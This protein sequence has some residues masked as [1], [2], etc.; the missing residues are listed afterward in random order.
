MPQELMHTSVR[1]IYNFVKI[2]L[3]QCLKVRTVFNFKN[4]RALRILKDSSQPP[5][6]QEL[7]IFSELRKPAIWNIQYILHYKFNN[8]KI[9]GDF[10]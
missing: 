10:Q 7:P 2:M 5:F 8:N 9:N 6:D 4:L 3:G 1:T